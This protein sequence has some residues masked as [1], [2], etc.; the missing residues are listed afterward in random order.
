VTSRWTAPSQ[1]FR[2]F[3]ATPIASTLKAKEEPMYLGVVFVYAIIL[4]LASPII[5]IVW[6]LLA[7]LSERAAGS[8]TRVH[9]VPTAES[10]RQV[11]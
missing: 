8:Y 10:R 5:W 6:W 9:A 7:D 4:V 1:A 2:L 3:I 11:A